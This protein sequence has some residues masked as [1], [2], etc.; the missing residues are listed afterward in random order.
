M[1]ISN[2]AIETFAIELTNTFV[3]YYCFCLL[4]VFPQNTFGT[5]YDA[6]NSERV[7]STAV[8]NLGGLN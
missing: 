2:F 5:V 3:M 1:K 7:E 6:Q 8:I 4:L